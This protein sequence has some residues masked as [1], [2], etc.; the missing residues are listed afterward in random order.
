MK[1]LTGNSRQGCKKELGGYYC[2]V[3]STVFENCPQN[4]SFFLLFFSTIAD[5]VVA[6]SAILAVTISWSW[7]PHLN[8]FAY[9][10]IVTPNY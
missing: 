4:V 9:V 10:I 7:P 6:Y 3:E 1:V 5:T 2:S 8:R